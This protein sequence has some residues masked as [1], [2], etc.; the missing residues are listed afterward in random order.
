MGPFALMDLIGHG[1]APPVP[2]PA[3]PQPLPASVTSHGDSELQLLL[4]RSGVRVQERRALPGE[5]HEPLVELPSGAALARCAGAT[6]ASMARAAGRPV[7]VVDRTLDDATATAI[8]LAPSSNCPGEA[9]DMAVGL[10]QSAGLRVFVVEDL[11]GLIV[12][13]TV[14]MLAN[15]AADA[16]AGRVA[17]AHDIDTAM[18][19]GVSY[20]RGPLAWAAGWGL[21]TVLTTL[22]AMESWYRDGHYRPSPLLRRAVLTNTPLS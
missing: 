14:A 21:R 4:A 15:L 19:L 11:P 6:A 18:R 13:R 3:P 17:C 1:A 2:A 7:I 10:L 9:V 8:A 22:D 5:R 12:T 20:P 16:L